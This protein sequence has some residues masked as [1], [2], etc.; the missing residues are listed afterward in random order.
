MAESIT[1]G[2]LSFQAPTRQGGMRKA[3]SITAGELIFQFQAP[4]RQGG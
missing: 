2:E 1:A 3:E 4:A